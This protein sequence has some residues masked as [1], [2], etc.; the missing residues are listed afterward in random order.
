ME[1]LG[2]CI[3]TGDMKISKAGIIHA[4]SFCNIQVSGKA[5]RKSR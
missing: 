3:Q 2:E 4:L 5:Q 1:Q